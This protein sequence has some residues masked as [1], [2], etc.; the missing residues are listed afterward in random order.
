M[1]FKETIKKVIS[2]VLAITLIVGSGNFI[3]DT[4]KSTDVEAATTKITSMD[5]YDSANGPTQTKSGVT[6]ASFGIVMPKFNGKPSQEL[7][8][9]DVEDDLQL[10]VKQANGTGGEWKLISAVDYFI[11]NDTWGWE[12]QIWSATADGWIAWFKLKETTQIKFQSKSSPSV[13]IEY[14]FTFN[15][16]NTYKL[17]S[18]SSGSEANITADAT[19]GSATHWGQWT[20]NGD[21]SITYDQISDDLTILVDNNDGKGFVNLLGNANSGFLWD[22][23]YGIYT[24]GTGGFWFTGIDWSFTLRLQKK[25][26]P[27]IYADAK[28][29]YNPPVR[30]NYTLTS[31]DGIT[32]Y[33]ARKDS[34]TADIGI[35]LPKIGNTAAVKADLNLFKYEVCVGATYNNGSW[36]GGEWILLN[37]V[38]DS[39]WI[40]QGNGYSKYSKSQ[41]WGYFIDTIYGL[42]FQ[43]VKKNTYLRIG[44]PENGKSGGAINNN[45]VYYTIIGDPDAKDP[46][47]PAMANITVDDNDDSTIYTPNG[48]SMIWNDEFNG[49][50]LDTSKWS[51]ETGYLL[52]EDDINTYGWGNQE[53][54]HYTDST[55]NVKVADGKLNISMK[56]DKKTFTQSN[57]STKKATALYS[58]GK[59][60]TKN[61]FSFKYGRVDIRMKAPKGDG[62]WPAAWM[63]PN[64]NIYGPWACSGEIDIFEGRGRIPNTVFGTLH[65]GAEWPSNLNTSDAFDMVTN[66][67]KGTDFSDWHVYSV[68]WEADQIKIYCDGICYFMCTNEMWYSGTDRG[69]ADAPFDQRFYMILNLAA[70]GSFD[71]FTVPGN[72]FAG[73]DMYVD[74]VRVFQRKVA[75][76]AD[77][78]PDTWQDLATN[79]KDDNLFGDYALGKG[80]TPVIPGDEPTTNPDVDNPTTAPNIEK[81]T[82]KPSVNVK[83]PG[84]VKI[85]K[86]Y[87]KKKASNKVKISLKRIKVAKGY[88]VA[89]YKTIK[90]A[91]KNKKALVKKSYKRRIIIIKSKKLRNKKKLYVKARAYVYKNG[92]RLYG[93]WSRYKRAKIK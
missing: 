56:N 32:S 33:D 86:I 6:E 74:Y 58:S 55:D 43:P 10:Y 46:D 80:S 25:G 72:D 51:Y 1:K 79:G 90:N 75:A 63:L 69:N 29:T 84:R 71:N 59:I 49:T 44:Y 19:G 41:Q 26:D 60:V 52:E 37:D 39:G 2:T 70:G 68:V 35:P 78:K 24:D 7:S 5:Y 89:I 36:S 67:S 92:R 61:K 83:K 50:S 85:T 54:Q 18:I 62:I 45:Y 66:G 38:A 12:H 17:T 87:K 30:N 34:H 15:K 64:N 11:F 48:W 73:A 40:Y 47:V 57:D 42:W 4:F 13:S 16:L 93:K 3:V 8:L 27:T 14:T 28:I 88:Q 9:E 77:E 82:T 91:K 65:Y 81:P 22:K 21:K 53:L 31:Y 20:F 23:N 76:N